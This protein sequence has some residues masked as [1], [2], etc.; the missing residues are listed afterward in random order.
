MKAIGVTMGASTL[1][2]VRAEDVSYA[3]VVLHAFD[4]LESVDPSVEPPAV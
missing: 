3:K 4:W 1:A 2:K